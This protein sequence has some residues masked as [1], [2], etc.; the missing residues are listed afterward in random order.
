VC[1]SFPVDTSIMQLK[2]LHLAFL[3][4]QNCTLSLHVVDEA[5]KLWFVAL[6]GLDVINPLTSR[7]VQ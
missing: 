2:A 7:E 1:I 3:V 4:N 6:I 5:G